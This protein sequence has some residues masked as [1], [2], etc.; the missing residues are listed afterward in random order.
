MRTVLNS[1]YFCVRQK[2]ISL[3]ENFKEHLDGNLF[4]L[5]KECLDSAKYSIR[6][7]YVFFL[8]VG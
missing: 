2:G 8:K 3:M 5:F 4:G 6:Q 1:D 7:N